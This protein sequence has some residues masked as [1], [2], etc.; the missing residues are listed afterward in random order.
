MACE[1]KNISYLGIQKTK[2]QNDVLYLANCK[3][4]RSTISISQKK[5]KELLTNNLINILNNYINKLEYN[6]NN[7]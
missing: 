5:A 2:Y 1:H 6:K 4:C 7:C 3:Q